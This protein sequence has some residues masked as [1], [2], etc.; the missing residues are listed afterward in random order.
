[1]TSTTEGGDKVEVEGRFGL[2]KPASE[3]DVDQAALS[4]CPVSGGDGR[5]VVVRLDLVAA[6]DSSLAAQVGVELSYKGPAIRPLDFVMGFN[7]PNCV[8]GEIQYAG[9][10]LGTIQPQQS[11]SLTVWVVLPDVI[12]P[13]DPHPSEQTLRDEGWF[14]EPPFLTLNGT[15]VAAG[16]A[17]E[18]GTR[19]SRVVSCDNNPAGKVIAVIGGM[20]QTLTEQGVRD[21]GEVCPAG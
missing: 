6:L 18:R 20:P 21:Y 3:S 15:A 2:P 8:L 10:S 1:M 4:Q 14:I 5:A 19:G 16:A 13:N 7:P 11:A 9:A 12:T 17:Q